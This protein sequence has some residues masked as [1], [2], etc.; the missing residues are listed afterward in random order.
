MKKLLAVLT[1]ILLSQP[2]LAE[3]LIED[4]FSADKLEGRRPARGEWK[5][6]DGAISVEFDKKLYEEHKSHGPI[7]WYIHKPVKDCTV[8]FKYMINNETN[9]VTF[10]YNGKGGHVY[11]TLIKKSAGNNKKN[12][13]TKSWDSEKK[14]SSMGSYDTPLK[15]GDWVTVKLTFKGNDLTIDHGEQSNKF[16]NEHI[17][18]DK[19]HFSIQFN[20]GNLKVKDLKISTD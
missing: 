20:G 14:S 9:G 10:T 4:N 11:R 16:T 19:S 12:T 3:A 13:I 15:E 17:S 8:E 7:L 6:A 1:A 18:R 5:V 2:L